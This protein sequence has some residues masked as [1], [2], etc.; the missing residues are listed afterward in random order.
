MTN[1][2]IQIKIKNINK[3]LMINRKIK[4]I[5]VKFNNKMGRQLGK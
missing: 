4:K 5:K 2:M 3:L 1:K